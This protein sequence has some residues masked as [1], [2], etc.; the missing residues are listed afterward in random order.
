MQL[1]LGQYAE[2]S[3]QSTVAITAFKKFLQLAPTDVEAA[4]VRKDLK[5]L[6]KST[7]ASTTAPSG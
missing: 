5:A 6:L 4:T 1:Q 3:G 7:G 2:A